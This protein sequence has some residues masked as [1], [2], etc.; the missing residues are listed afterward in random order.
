MLGGLKT[1]PKAGEDQDKAEI[2]VSTKKEEEK[3]GSFENISDEPSI[4]SP[5]DTIEIIE[6]EKIEITKNGKKRKVCIVID[7]MR[8]FRWKKYQVKKM[9][10]RI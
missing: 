8:V 2:E 10:M 4:A 9:G 6:D 5:G 7:I 1:A 3:K